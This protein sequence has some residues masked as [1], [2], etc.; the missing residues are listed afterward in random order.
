MTLSREGLL[1]Q[2]EF[3]ILLFVLGTVLLNWPFL[4]LASP[5][6]KVFGYPVRLVYLAVAWLLI[7]SWAYLIDRRRSV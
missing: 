7:I 5:D 1:D 3:W 6:D 4:S 2:P